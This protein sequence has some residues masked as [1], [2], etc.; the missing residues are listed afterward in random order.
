MTLTARKHRWMR[1]AWMGLARTLRSKA[2]LVDLAVAARGEHFSPL[3]CP[4]L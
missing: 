4:G 1:M 3:L 2:T